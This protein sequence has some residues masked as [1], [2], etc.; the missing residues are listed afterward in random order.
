M[1][2]KPIKLSQK[3]LSFYGTAAHKL[4]IL[5]FSPQRP[6]QR[7]KKNRSGC[8]WRKPE[9]KKK[10]LWPT[11]SDQIFGWLFV[12]GSFVLRLALF[13]HFFLTHCWTKKQYYI[14]AF[15]IVML[16]FV[17]F[18]ILYTFL[19]NLL[20]SRLWGNITFQS[21][22]CSCSYLENIFSLYIC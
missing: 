22:V 13:R 12:S 17:L 14:W 2:R 9:N 11:R 21:Q 18:L 15:K 4:S 3:G 10:R 20:A 1:P 8:S 16:C 6:W 19:V 5:L 7:W